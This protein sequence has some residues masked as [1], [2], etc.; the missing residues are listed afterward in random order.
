MLYIHVAS[1][2]IIDENR[3]K[4]FRGVNGPHIMF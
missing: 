4:V 2:L 1:N 3:E